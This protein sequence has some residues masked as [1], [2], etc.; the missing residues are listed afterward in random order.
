MEKIITVPL[1]PMP[2][3]NLLINFEI[4]LFSGTFAFVVGVAVVV[5]DGVTGVNVTLGIVVVVAAAMV[6]VV[7]GEGSILFC[8]VSGTLNS[9]GEAVVDVAVAVVIDDVDVGA[10]VVDG[11]VGVLGTD[12]DVGVGCAVVL[13]GV[14]VT[15]EVALVAVFAVVVAVAVLI[16]VCDDCF[17]CALRLRAGTKTFDFVLSLKVSLL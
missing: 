7:E 2:K 15:T 10:D 16:E 12:V 4:P 9:P 5:V 13:V 14:E 3:L 8:T 6:V 1:L 17:C 11:V